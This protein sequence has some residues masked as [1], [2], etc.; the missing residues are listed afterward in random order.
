M[1]DQAPA[2]PAASPAWDVAPLFPDQGTWSEHDYLALPGNRLVE[3]SD[4]YIEVP[5]MPTTS[6][7]RI[8]FFLCRALSAVVEPGQ[9]GTVLPAPLR[10]RLWSGKY[11]EPDVV[12]MRSEHRE[13]MGEQYWD[14]ADLVMEVVSADDPQRDLETKRSEYALAGIPEY[15]IV[16]PRARRITVL[17]LDGRTYAVHVE[18]G[19]GMQAVSAH[20]D[21]LTLSVDSV[22][23]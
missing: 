7:Q 16:D 4:G 14:G 11:R 12:F 2:Q 1:A 5:P 8:V 19:P 10:V 3:L 18:A 9:L 22:L 6:H 20:I 15:W 17:R 23:P 13:R 21:G